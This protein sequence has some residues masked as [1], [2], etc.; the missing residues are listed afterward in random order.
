MGFVL[1]APDGE[2]VGSLDCVF[3]LYEFQG[4]RFTA[5]AQAGWDVDPA[6][7]GSSLQLIGASFR[8][9]GIDIVI[10]GSSS[11]AAAKIM[12]ALKIPRMPIPEYARPCF[13]AIR[14]GAVVKAALLR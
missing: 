8:L 11:L 4:R 3:L 9:P 2:I 13:W 10:N 1:E 5:I 7:R 12:T 14:P 6:Y